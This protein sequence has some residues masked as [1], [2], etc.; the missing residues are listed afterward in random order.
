MYID[1]LPALDLMRHWTAPNAIPPGPNRISAFLTN[2]CNLNCNH[3]WRNWAD[4]DRSCKS[5]LPDARWL[6]LIDEAAEMNVRQWIL[7]GGG[8][9]LVRLDLAMQMLKKMTGYNMTSWIYTN[10]TLFT[11]ETMDAIVHYNAESI[12]FSI[13]GPTAEIN[14]AIRGRGFDRAMENLRYLAKRK[15]E[16]GTS[17]PDLFIYATITNLTYDKIDDFVDLAASSGED[18]RVFLSTLI[19]QGESTAQFAL[20]PEQKAA[21][22]DWVQKALERAEKMGIVNNFRNFIDTEIIEDTSNMQRNVK[23]GPCLGLSGALCYEPWLSASILPDGAMGP[24]CAFYDPNA[25]SIK[26][27]TLNEVWNGAYM[28]QVR[29]GMFNGKPPLY[30][31]RCPANLFADKEK[32]RVFLTEYLRRDQE[33]LPQH[34]WGMLQRGGHTLRSQGFRAL[35]HQ[36]KEWLALRMRRNNSPE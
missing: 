28:N 15:K 12:H 17:T 33:S 13:D 21:F 11:P 34:L 3:C 1:F 5:E 10:G 29:E 4:W 30:C 2:K 27:K 32:I 31:V 7:L 14:N 25:L 24:C 8:E 20:N 9:P 35:G 19:V 18:I 36:A 22:P 6:N 23:A 26:D 16:C